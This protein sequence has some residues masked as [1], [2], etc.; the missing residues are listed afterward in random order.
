MILDSQPKI[1]VL[2]LHGVLKLRPAFSAVDGGGGN[3]VQ[4]EP[5]GWRT[6]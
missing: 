1:P 4:V 2:G 6:E 5:P 3:P